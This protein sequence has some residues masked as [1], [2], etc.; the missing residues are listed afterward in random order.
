MAIGSAALPNPLGDL[1]L[2]K[3]KIAVKPRVGP[4]LFDRIQVLALQIFNQGQFKNLPVAGLADDGR[5]IREAKF[6]RRAPPAFA[7]DQL[8]LVADLLT[9][10]G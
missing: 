1:F 5:C 8:V 10:S 6:A 9:M 4:G 3:A 2:G 7:R